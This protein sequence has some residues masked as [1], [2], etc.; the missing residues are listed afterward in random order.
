MIDDS[1][2]FDEGLHLAAGWSYW[3]DPRPISNPDH[4]PL[5]NLISAFPLFFIKIIPPMPQI[6]IYPG[7]R[8]EILGKLFY[9]SQWLLYRSWPGADTILLWSRIPPLILSVFLML[10]VYSWGKRLYG[11]SAGLISLFLY[12]FSPDLLAHSRLIKDDVGG[13]A[14]AVICLYLL[15]MA[16]RSGQRW[17]YGLLGVSYGCALATKHTA[18]A[19][20]PLLVILSVAF[21]VSRDKSAGVP[22]GLVGR[23]LGRLLGHYCWVLLLAGVV[24]LGIYKVRYV[25]LYVDDLWRTLV[26]P[27]HG[28]TTFLCEE[29]SQTGFFQYFL[30]AFLIKT[31]LAFISLLILASLVPRPAGLSFWRDEAFVLIPALAYFTAASLSRHNIGSRHILLVYPL[32]FIFVGRCAASKSCFSPSAPRSAMIRL[33]PIAVPLLIAWYIASSLAVFPHHLSYFNEL[34]GGPRNGYRYLSDSNIDWGQDLKRLKKAMDRAG[35]QEIYLSYFGEAEPS[36]YGIQY[37]SLLPDGPLP[38]REFQRRPKN[39]WLAISVKCLQGVSFSDHDIFAWLKAR[40]PDARVGYS[41]LL[42]DLTGRI[43]DYVNLAKIYR[44]TGHY[45]LADL[46][47]KDALALDPD[48][49][50]AK[51]ALRELNELK[52]PGAARR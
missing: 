42:Y 46:E 14:F 13:A 18:V 5:I 10:I 33:L 20:L 50:S 29:Y 8:G 45:M 38:Y 25:N 47:I 36:Y 28:Y 24:I 51:Q 19:L 2:T 6:P 39:K 16:L 30:V 4:P 11:P 41:I 12:A 34:I 52:E 26:S 48:D 7:M 40:L 49:P 27:R 44:L 17:Q 35:L 32:L 21:T 22:W 9:L 23:Q 3:H 37:Q 1:A 15:W 43:S 31:P